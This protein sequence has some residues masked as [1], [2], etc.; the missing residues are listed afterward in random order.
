MI[1]II[2]KPF[3]LELTPAIPIMASTILTIKKSEV[4]VY[5]PPKDSGEVPAFPGMIK[6]QPALIPKVDHS[7]SGCVPKTLPDMVPMLKPF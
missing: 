1:R 6:A 3:D 7:D 5:E 4:A 2:T